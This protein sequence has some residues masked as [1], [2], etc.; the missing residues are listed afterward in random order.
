[1]HN[2]AVHWHEGLFLRP[3]HLQAWDRHWQEVTTAADRWQ[4]P[5]SYGIAQISI[6]PDALSAGFFQLDSVRARTLEGTLIE[7]TLGEGT[8]RL[9]LRPAFAR[10]E[11]DETAT[12]PMQG[13]PGLD[14]YLGVPRLQLG[15]CNVSLANTEGPSRF[16]Q[17][18]Q[19]VPDDADGSSV[20]PILFRRMNAR[21]LVS[22]DDHAGYE[23]L[24]VARVV[25]RSS[26]GVMAALDPMYVPPLMDC[27]A[28]PAMRQFFLRPIFD[29]IA[30]KSTA[31]AQLLRDHSLDTSG[32]QWSDLQRIFVLQALNQATSISN[33]LVQSRGL[34][35]L[36][37]YLEIAKIVGSL[38]LLSPDFGS[39]PLAPYDHEAIGPLF[40][41]LR[42]RI[43]KR[44]K[45]AGLSQYAQR[46]FVGS[47]RIGNG[48]LAKGMQLSLASEWLQPNC[49]R[50]FAVHRGNLSAHEI[51]TLLAPGNLDWKL[52]SSAQVE[53]LFQQRTSGVDIRPLREVPKSLPSQAEWS[54]FEIDETGPAWSDVLKTR[55]LALRFRETLIVNSNQLEGEKSIVVRSQQQELPLQFAVFVLGSNEN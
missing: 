18:Q 31:L 4:S 16:Q 49:T 23:T 38:D 21:L 9:D 29:L 37:V 24:R 47:K 39:Q 22:T 26:A 50:V 19:H 5:H 17:T 27:A 1:M 43:E 42:A 20:E 7:L 45:L 13:V 30:S 6:N 53:S 2:L 10:L 55:T 11:N 36:D 52:G 35:P 15:G 51:E 48:G 44:L 46:F 34:H 8:Q 3:Q 33:I 40:A 41:S 54:Y 25:R 12:I 14:I 32:R 28:W